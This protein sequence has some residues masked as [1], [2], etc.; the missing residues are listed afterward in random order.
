[1]PEIK[2]EKEW[3]DAALNQCAVELT[4]MLKS[5]QAALAKSVTDDAP[6]EESE[7]SEGPASPPPSDASAGSDGPPPAEASAP[8]PGGEVSAPDDGTPPASPEQSAAAAAPEG[9]PEHEAGEIEPAPTMEALQ[10]EYMKLDPEALKMHYLA[11]KG[12]LAAAM[13]AAGAGPEASAPAAPPAPPAAAAP[14]PG[15]APMA[16]GEM[17]GKQI[18][19]S[20]GNGG[21]VEKGKMSKSEKD[22]EIEGLKKQL[23]EQNKALLQLAEV[24]ATPIRKSVKGLSDLKFIERTDETP[25]SKTA[26]L[27]KK[28]VQ[29]ALSEKVRS[30]KLSKADKELVLKYSVGGVDLTK[31]EHLLA[32]AK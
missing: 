5:E 10:A 24:V 31:I 7:G 11:A 9:T 28:E 14:P 15:A 18:D 8:P 19:L 17:K 13:G 2:F 32:D 4:D 12:A 26:T 3:L 29:A 21:E 23:E 20:D 1:M 25:P 30:G 22:V 27:S 16:M 6:A